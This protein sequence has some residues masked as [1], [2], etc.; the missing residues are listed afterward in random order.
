MLGLEVSSVGAGL[1][2]I[3]LGVLVVALAVSQERGRDQPAAPQGAAVRGQQRIIGAAPTPACITEFFVRPPV[4]ASHRRRVLLAEVED[5]VVLK[6]AEPKRE[7]FGLVLVEQS[8][9]IGAV[10]MSYDID[11]QRFRIDGLIDARCRRAD[12]TAPAMPGSNPSIV[13]NYTAP[14]L[15]LGDREYVLGLKAA[16]F[17]ELE[18]HRFER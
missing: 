5:V 12:W 11:T 13:N 14:R 6:R 18:L 1:P 10:K 3:A 9:V 7:E 4:V 8:N 2:L 16:D 15:M 17:V